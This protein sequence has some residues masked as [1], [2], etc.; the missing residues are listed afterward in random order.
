MLTPANAF[1]RMLAA[2]AVPLALAGCEANSE[3]SAEGSAATA[4][5]AA[6]Q[7]A[8]HSTPTRTGYADVEGGRINYQVY[9]DLNSG[10]TPLL[11]LHGSFMSGDAMQPFVEPFAAS[12]P[13][14]AIDAR[15]HG[16]TGDLPG[17]ITVILG[18]GKR[19]FG[20][21][22]LPSAMRMVEHQIT[23]RGN[24]IATYEPDGS[25][26]TGSFGEQEPSAAE[27]ER[28]EKVELGTW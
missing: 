16:R 14:I 13:V 25:V 12:R 23:P 21:G 8:A 5:E 22:T 19:L 3:D 27:L 9:G 10:K 20:D 18:S 17:P 6:G 1:R 15:G 4:K 28:R 24:I 26:E 2:A 7:T 11:V